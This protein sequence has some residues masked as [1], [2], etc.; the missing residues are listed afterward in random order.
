MVGCKRKEVLK[1]T[2]R[3]EVSVYNM[4]KYKTEN[5][6]GDYSLGGFYLIFDTI[7]NKGYIGKSINTINRLKSHYYNAIN[8]KGIAIDI[9]MHNRISDFRFYIIDTYV[10]LGINF[11]NRKLEQVYEH[12]LIGKFKTYHPYGY[13]MR[14]YDKLRIK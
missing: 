9:S 6:T 2:I 7:N 12:A 1:I 4:L 5:K 10:N 8:N 13:N 11:F 14:Y 3:E